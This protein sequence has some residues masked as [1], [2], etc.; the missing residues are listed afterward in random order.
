MRLR[1]IG[2]ITC[3]ILAAVACLAASQTIDPALNALWGSDITAGELM[4]ATDPAA[5]AHMSERM[6]DTKVTWASGPGPMRG[7]ARALKSEGLAVG[8]SDVFLP[9][10]CFVGACGLVVAG[11]AN[12]LRIVRPRTR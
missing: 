10:A 7:V 2:C 9:L 11:R 4:A 8:L 1:R 3:G 5:L 12:R 6:K